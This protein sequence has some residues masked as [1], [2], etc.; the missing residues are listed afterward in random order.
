MVVQRFTPPAPDFHDAGALESIPGRPIEDPVFE[1]VV[2]DA[3][4]PPFQFV[5]PR[6]IVE[7]ADAVVDFPDR[8]CADV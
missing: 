6:Q 5:A 8:D 7:S 4:E 1:E 2:Q 3:S